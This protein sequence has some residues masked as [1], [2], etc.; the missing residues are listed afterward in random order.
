MPKSKKI[1]AKIAEVKSPIGV[2][3]YAARIPIKQHNFHLT[4][5]LYNV[6]NSRIYL[7]PCPR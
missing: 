1:T 6:Y 4:S 3:S 2:T 5:E 7:F